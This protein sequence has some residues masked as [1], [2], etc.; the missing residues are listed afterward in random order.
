MVMSV[1]PVYAFAE[2]GLSDW[3]Y[4]VLSEEEKTAEITGYNGTD[5]E[6]LFPEEI[7]GYRM[8]A[9]ADEAFC[10]A[11][12]YDY[13][14]TRIYVPDTYK[15]IGD[16]NFRYYRNL[17]EVNMKQKYLFITGLLLCVA[18]VE[19]TMKKQSNV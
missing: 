5:T 19:R 9:I 16:A 2:D 3:T 13:P 15:R 12:Y 8:V 1:L 7:N 6:L 11:S 18:L 10:G 4:N 14:I 17:M